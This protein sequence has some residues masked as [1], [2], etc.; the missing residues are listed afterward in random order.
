M[1]ERVG[2]SRVKLWILITG[3]RLYVAGIFLLGTL[4]FLLIL[5]TFG[6]HSIRT[7][8]RTDAVGSLFGSVVIAIAIV[9]SVTL[10]LAISQFVLSKE[11]GSLGEQRNRMQNAVNFR[12]DVESAS[13]IG[14]SPSA[15]SAFLR[16]LVEATEVKA[17]MLA[18]AVVEND[19]PNEAT[20]ALMSYADGVIDHSEKVTNKLR[21]AEFGSVEVLLSVL[22]Y[23]YSWKIAAARKLRHDYGD[24]ISEATDATLGELLEMLRYF[25]PARAHFKTLYFQWESINLARS[26]LYTALP[27]L[28]LAAY[29]ILMFDPMAVADITIGINT[30][31]LVVS[32][33][34][35]VT[36]A[37]FALL[38][39]Y[40]LRIL[41]VA[42][43]ALTP[44]PFILQESELSDDIY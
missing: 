10:V 30:S 14:P 19:D 34:F 39:S 1:R 6:P 8:L 28:A 26:L 35:V 36:L 3:G 33:V 37:P 18:N 9:T 20:Q 25:G 11:I 27:S 41:T 31:L 2:E 5:G 12:E 24:S 22:N 44:G 7:L 43:R 38:L 13:E 32:T 23:N 29:M 16:A 17:E 21:G 15:P 42:K 40:L 4:T